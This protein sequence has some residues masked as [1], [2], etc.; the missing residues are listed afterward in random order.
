MRVYVSTDETYIDKITIRG[1]SDFTAYNNPSF[2]IY[3]ISNK[4]V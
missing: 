2:S 1:Y 4:R 3:V